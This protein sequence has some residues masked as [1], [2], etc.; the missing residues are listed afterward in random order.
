VP[1]RPLGS[2]L[3]FLS[4]FCFPRALPKF[5]LSCAPHSPLTISPLPTLTKPLHSVPSSSALSFTHAH[6]ALIIAHPPFPCTAYTATHHCSSPINFP[7][8]L[9]S[10]LHSQSLLTIACIHSPHLSSQNSSLSTNILNNHTPPTA[11]LNITSLT[12]P[13]LP[14][15]YRISLS[16]Y[17]SPESSPLSYYTQHPLSPCS[18]LP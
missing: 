6:L 1:S 2:F 9:H 12:T 3:P 5:Q 8:P 7:P 17:P 18:L 14:D 13:H 11:A 10:S 4:G 15:T 16:S